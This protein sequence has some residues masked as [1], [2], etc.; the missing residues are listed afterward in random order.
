MAFDKQWSSEDLE[1][2]KA[3]YKE[4]EF[5]EL[6]NRLSRSEASVRWKASQLRMVIP[7]VDYTKE[8]DRFILRAYKD[9]MPL[10][11][12]A[13][14]IGRTKSGINKRLCKIAPRT[15]RNYNR[16]ISPIE[17]DVPINDTLAESYRYMLFKLELGSSFV[18]PEKHRQ[19][20]NNQKVFFPKKKFITKKIS[21][22]ERRLW[23]VI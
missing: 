20:I 22:L 10:Q 14:K 1:I 16:I 2:L 23:R 9:G 18:Y 15:T 7:K 19:H 6:C 5:K 3:G 12:I 11:D 21:V 4:V 13:D 8:D 17:M